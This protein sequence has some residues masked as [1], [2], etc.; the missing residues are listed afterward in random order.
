[1]KSPVL[2]VS[3]N[4]PQIVKLQ[5][6]ALSRGLTVA[7]LLRGLINE[8][9]SESERKVSHGENTSSYSR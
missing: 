4:V 1:V 3:L 6:L 7:A 9:I 2:K 8:A 5:A